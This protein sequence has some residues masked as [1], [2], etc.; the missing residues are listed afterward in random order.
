MNDWRD[1]EHHQVH[2]HLGA[3]KS[4]SLLGMWRRAILGLP[5]VVGACVAAPEARADDGAVA[6]GTVFT[7]L[8]VSDIVFTIYSAIKVDENG[9]QLNG[10]G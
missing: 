4:A 3:A 10:N 9:I 2:S 8:A 7:G 5:I 6:L 1:S